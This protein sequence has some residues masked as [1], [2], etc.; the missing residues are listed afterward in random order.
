[1]NLK[2]FE[3]KVASLR[4]ELNPKNEFSSEKVFA[5]I[6]SIDEAQ[7][8]ESCELE[9]MAFELEEYVPNNIGTQCLIYLF[10]PRKNCIQDEIK[11]AITAKLVEKGIDLEGISYDG[12]TIQEYI[13]SSIHH[14]Q[15]PLAPITEIFITRHYRFEYP[16][17]WSFRAAWG[18]IS[19]SDI[20]TNDNAFNL[21]D[22]IQRNY[23]S[24]HQQQVPL[25]INLVGYSNH[26]FDNLEDFK[27]F[28][29]NEGLITVAQANAFGADEEETCLDLARS[30]SIM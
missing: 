26:T 11:I 8:K 19:L 27:T 25:I 16:K 21:G 30:C 22:N 2:F 6:E 18:G 4:E 24:Y 7:I 20:L 9:Q 14:V 1:M 5:L 29:V 3:D 15:I 28:L 17:A 13:Q 23:D 10:S 12:K